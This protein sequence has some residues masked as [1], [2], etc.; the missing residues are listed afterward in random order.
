MTNENEAKLNKCPGTLNCPEIDC[1]GE[2]PFRDI[3]EFNIAV[4]SHCEKCALSD[5]PN[6]EG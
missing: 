3:V 5:L 1:L 6:G 4:L 2:Y